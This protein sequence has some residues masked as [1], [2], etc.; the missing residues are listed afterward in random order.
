[1]CLNP[2]HCCDDT[3]ADFMAMLKTTEADDQLARHSDYR[4][5]RYKYIGKAGWKH[6]GVAVH[7]KHA[8][9]WKGNRVD[10]EWGPFHEE[11]QRTLDPE[12]GG[13][14]EITTNQASETGV[15]FVVRPPDLTSEPR[16]EEFSED[17]EFVPEAACK[18][19]QKSRRDDL[20]PENLAF[21]EALQEYHEGCSKSAQQVWHRP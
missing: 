8:L 2:V 3:V 18:R 7:F 10:C 19:I 21:W 16:R 6:G 17:K 20:T 11:K 14:K 9:A 4:V 13:E 15:R 1:M 5:W 12:G